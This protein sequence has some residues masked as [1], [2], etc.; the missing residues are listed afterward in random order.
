MFICRDCALENHFEHANFVKLTV[1]ACLSNKGQEIN[2]FASELASS[3]Y[4]LKV[5]KMKTEFDDILNTVSNIAQGNI[6]KLNML[7]ANID[8]AIKNEEEMSNNLEQQVREVYNN[9]IVKNL[10]YHFRNYNECKLLLI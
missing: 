2:I 5:D 10:N 3:K 7:K 9:A 1:E 8:E 4:K 6:N